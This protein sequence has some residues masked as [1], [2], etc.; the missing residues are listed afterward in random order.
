VLV[1]GW[2]IFGIAFLTFEAGSLS[3]GA[4]QGQ[5]V[6]P[7]GA[8]KFDLSQSGAISYSQWPWGDVSIGSV[9][10]KAVKGLV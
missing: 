6:S 5:Y 1:L 2:F 4:P 3:F 10:G 8:L 9:L 7:V